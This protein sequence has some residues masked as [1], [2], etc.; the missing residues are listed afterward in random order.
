MFLLYLI[1]FS[2]KHQRTLRA[3]IQENTHEVVG[4]KLHSTPESESPK[5]RYF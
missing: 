3:L 4:Y 5:I 1:Y 2:T